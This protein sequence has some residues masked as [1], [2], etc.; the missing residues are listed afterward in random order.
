MSEAYVFETEDGI[1]IPVIFTKKTN[2]KNIVLHPRAV[3]RWEIRVSIPWGGNMRMALAFLDAKR[4]W[5]NKFFKKSKPKQ[6]LSSGDTIVFCGRNYCVIHDPRSR[7]GIYYDDDKMFVCGGA[8]MLERRV[9][10][11]IKREFLKF[12]VAE[13]KKINK[14]FAYKPTRI[15]LKDTTSR[16]GS[17]SSSG[18]VAFS[19]R[20]AFAPTDVARYVIIHEIS[21]LKYLDHSA[22]FWRTV[23]ELHGPGVERAK[24][25]LSAHGSELH[26]LF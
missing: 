23:R 25:W 7:A 8:D 22:A 14:T 24:L 10:D 18:S 19:W 26:Q 4:D 17:C 15:S 11:E 12:V 3:P 2:G 1:E 9:R 13:V 20:L 6:K 5:I 16:W 21:H